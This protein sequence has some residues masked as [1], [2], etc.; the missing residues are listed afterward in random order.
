MSTKSK[1]KSLQ[2]RTPFRLITFLFSCFLVWWATICFG[3]L[4]TTYKIKNEKF[5]KIKIHSLEKLTKNGLS[6]IE[7][8]KYIK[9]AEENNSQETKYNS[10]L[11]SLNY[12]N[13]KFIFYIF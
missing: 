2:V 3:F 11:Q 8:K 12:N 10:Q 13:I 4:H 9:I 1:V 6:E 7:A 5:V